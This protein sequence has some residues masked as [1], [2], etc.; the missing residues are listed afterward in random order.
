MSNSQIQNCIGIRNDKRLPGFD[1]RNH[2]RNNYYV[3]NDLTHTSY[4]DKQINSLKYTFVILRVKVVKNNNQTDNQSNQ[5]DA[6]QNI[7]RDF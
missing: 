5:C 7:Q 3:R 6:D 4:S 2:T 1:N